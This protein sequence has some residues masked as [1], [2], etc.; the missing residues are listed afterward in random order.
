MKTVDGSVSPNIRATQS[1]NLHALH[2]QWFD[3]FSYAA[4]IQLSVMCQHVYPFKRLHN[5]YN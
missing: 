5:G 2:V 3:K 4:V 1:L